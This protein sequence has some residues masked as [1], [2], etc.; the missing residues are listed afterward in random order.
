MNQGKLTLREVGSRSADVEFTEL[1][2]W[3]KVALE[4]AAPHED[5]VGM[6]PVEWAAQSKV[7][8]K[9][10]VTRLDPEYSLEGDFEA[11]VPILCPRCGAAGTAARASDFRLFMR[12][13]GP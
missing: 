4:K 10:K 3:V 2:P 6:S 9:L 1:D 5:L 12:P 11:R 8:G 7:K 13:L